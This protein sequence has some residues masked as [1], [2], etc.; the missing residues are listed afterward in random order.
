MI[1]IPLT[2]FTE[3]LILNNQTFNPM[4]DHRSK[5]AVQWANSAKDVEADN[6]MLKQ[7]EKLNP[8]ELNV[9]TRSGKIKLNIPD[10]AGYFRVLMW[11]KGAKTPDFMT[12]WV[13]V[14]SNKIYTLNKE[15]FTPSILMMGTG[16]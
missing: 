13:D 6:L 10:K 12:N 14:E 4:D 3:S 1:I 16:C 5:M 7:G 15:H 9:L 11:S 2:G 8:R